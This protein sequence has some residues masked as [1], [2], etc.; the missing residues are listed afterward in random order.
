MLKELQ[1]KMQSPAASLLIIKTAF[2]VCTTF[3][4][5]LFK[6]IYLHILKLCTHTILNL[7]IWDIYLN[8]DML[9]QFFSFRH[10]CY[11]ATP[12]SPY[13][14]LPSSP[15]PYS[16]ALLSNMVPVSLN[17]LPLWFNRHRKGWF[18]RMVSGGGYSYSLRDMEVMV[19]AS[20][21]NCFFLDFPPIFLFSFTPPN[22]FNFI[23]SE[24][25][26]MNIIMDL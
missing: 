6:N 18:L 21:F 4:S 9:F 22:L 17:F 20:I 11:I 23:T 26:T 24:C 2:P 5:K 13:F 3:N 15:P 16:P 8:L 7:W 14:I 1:L 10:L 19:G 25:W 12:Y